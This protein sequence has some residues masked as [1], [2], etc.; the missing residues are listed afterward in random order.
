MQGSSSMPV[1]SNPIAA[2]ASH[3]TRPANATAVV[4]SLATGAI[5]ANASHDLCPLSIGH[6]AGGN[7]VCNR[8][9]RSALRLAPDLH[10]DIA[11]RA[12]DEQAG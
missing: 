1:I 11:L 4:I 5:I 12:A 2:G 10:D 9:R 6:G 7:A 8:V 3:E